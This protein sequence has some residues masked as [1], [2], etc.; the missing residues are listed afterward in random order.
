MS[1]ET[2]HEISANERVKAGVKHEGVHEHTLSAPKAPGFSATARGPQSFKTLIVMV[3][4]SDTQ[5]TSP[6]SAWGAKIFG[7]AEGQLNHYYDQISYGKA[8]FAPAAETEGTANDGFVRVRLNYPHPRPRNDQ[9]M[10]RVFLAEALTLTD[11][12][13]DFSAYDSDS[14]GRVSSSELQLGFLVAGGEAAYGDE[15]SIWAHCWNL[16]DARVLDG[17]RVASDSGGRYFAWGERHGDHDATLGIIA[18][19]IGHSAFNLPDLYPNL[20]DWDLMSTGN[21]GRKSNESWSGQT[22]VAMSAHTRWQ[23]GFIDATYVDPMYAVTTH[24]L[25]SGLSATPNLVVTTLP[26]ATARY[27]ALEHRRIEG[28]DLGLTSRDVPAGHSGVFV[29]SESNTRV[30]L[31]IVRA[32]T[33]SVTSHLFYPGNNDRLAPDTAPNTND[34]ADGTVT[35]YLFSNIAPGGGAMTVRIGRAPTVPGADCRLFTASNSAHVTAGRAHTVTSGTW[36]KTTTYYAV[37]SEENLGTLA[38]TQ[39][40]L[41]ETPVGYFAKGTSCP[42]Q[43]AP[44]FSDVQVIPDGARTSISGY[45]DDVEKDLV[46]VEIEVDALGTWQ[47]VGKR[48]DDSATQKWN[49]HHAID[50]LAQGQHSYRLRATDAG[51]RVTA[52]GPFQFIAEG[53]RPPTCTID[54]VH[55]DSAGYYAAWGGLSDQDGGQLRV[56][57]SLDGG[58]WRKAFVNWEWTLRLS[59]QPNDLAHGIHSVMARVTDETG[60]TGVCGPFEVEVGV[61][62]APTVVVTQMNQ[63]AD[64]INLSG[65]V[66]DV[67]GDLAGVEVEFD[68]NG[69]WQPVTYFSLINAANGQWQETRTGLAVGAHTV[70]ARGVDTAGLRGESGEPFSFEVFAPE[71]PVC[72]INSVDMTNG[73]PLVTGTV[74]D[75]NNDVVTLESFLVDHGTWLQMMYFGGEE[76]FAMAAEV[77][78]PA[79]RYTARIRVA[80]TRGDYGY[81]SKEFVVGAAPTLG[82]VQ[83]ATSGLTVTVSGTASDADND[84]TTVELQYDDEFGPWI[85][86]TG[87]T[88]WSHGNGTLGAGQHRVRIRARDAAGLTSASSE[89]RS[90]TLSSASCFTAANTAHAAAGRATLK[91]SVLYYANGSNDYLGMG[92][93]ATSLLQQGTNNWKKVTSCP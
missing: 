15:K 61:N 24:N 51:N 84:L 3:E 17:V 48:F 21:W 31:E 76:F 73:Y 4:F 32:G 55:R 63:S 82:S 64:A 39:V 1:D 33:S 52:F 60:L 90:F 41:K 71:P 67:D 83:V 43:N 29:L 7:T 81:C 9:D 22:P 19:E 10:T 36:W 47:R 74:T 65:S 68:G 25:H 16:A 75:R 57:V 50:G 86:A 2:L 44:V 79:G 37:G 13:V 53:P 30:G 38:N 92:T 40:T 69:Q 26:N 27:F 91:Y 58:A 14:D 23:A 59:D 6:T 87:T 85:A 66:E 54:R 56:D 70:R 72:I 35:G 28:Y 8:R 45:V 46:W 34:P 12:W 89:W 49:F 77:N 88:S 78:P 11:A 93:A 42:A 5:I 62:H 18:H 20:A 80:D